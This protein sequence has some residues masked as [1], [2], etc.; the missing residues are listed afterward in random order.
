[1]QNRQEQM[2]NTQEQ[3]QNRQEQMHNTQEQMHNT[4]VQMQ[5]TQVRMLATIERLGQL[6]QVISHNSVAR[7]SNVHAKQG[8]STLMPLQSEAAGHVRSHPQKP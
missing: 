1:M 8:S 5:N 7:S 4:Q 2:H 6:Q 3:M